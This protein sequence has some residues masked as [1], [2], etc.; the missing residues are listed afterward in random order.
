MDYLTFKLLHGISNNFAWICN[1]L[2][3]M[4]WAYTVSDLVLIV[5]QRDLNFM[6][7]CFCIAFLKRDLYLHVQL[8]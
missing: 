2:W 8:F 5:G 3:F 6:G 4:L 1:I 7:E